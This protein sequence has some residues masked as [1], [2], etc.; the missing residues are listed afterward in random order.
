[1]AGLAEAVSVA[2]FVAGI[3]RLHLVKANSVMTP[4]SL[5]KAAHPNVDVNRLPTTHPDA[6]LDQIIGLVVS[7][8][9]DAIAVIEGGVIAGVITMR[10]LL[11]GVQ[12]TA[13]E[14]AQ[15]AGE[16]LVEVSS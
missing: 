11:R 12:G 7:N 13:N 15:P 6:D 5:Y 1:M 8:D 10:D 14:Y 3:S 2:E 4:V 16:T 9:R